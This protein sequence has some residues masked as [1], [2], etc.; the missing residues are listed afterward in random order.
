MV[1]FGAHLND[2]GVSLQ[3]SEPQYHS[4][5]DAT[6]CSPEKSRLDVLFLSDEFD[7]ASPLVEHTSDY[8]LVMD[9][10]ERGCVSL[11]ISLPLCSLTAEEASDGNQSLAISAR[12]RVSFSKQVECYEIDTLDSYSDEEYDATWY[13]PDDSLAMR[14]DCIRTVHV[15][16]GQTPLEDDEVCFR[17]LEC[18][19]GHCLQARSSRKALSRNSVL[20]E[21][22]FYR[23]LKVD[24]PNAIAVVAQQYSAP[25]VEA[26]IQVAKRDHAQA[27]DQW[28][29]HFNEDE[30]DYSNEIIVKKNWFHAALP[31][32]PKLAY[33][34]LLRNPLRNAIT[35]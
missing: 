3:H 19:T 12:S 1:P 29:L 4:S 7:C 24:N 6:P 35:A 11:P 23:D 10:C 5:W 18:K 15:M 25:S 9:D 28:M 32:A 13:T 31:I 27:C 8:S 26:A 2:H 17:G 34:N 20:E 30:W 14:N 21:Q 33:F 22:A 16:I